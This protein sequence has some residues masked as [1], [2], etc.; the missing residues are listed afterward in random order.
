[1]SSW[2]AIDHT[3]AQQEGLVRGMAMDNVSDKVR[4]RSE[5]SFASIRP[6]AP[7]EK[8]VNP[9]T[10]PGQRASFPSRLATLNGAATRH[11][12]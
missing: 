9:V 8:T 12:K 10:F 2:S 6:T 7:T 1:M 11:P 5:V 4:A 3:R